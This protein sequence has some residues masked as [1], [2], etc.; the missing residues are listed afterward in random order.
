MRLMPDESL[1]IRDV[2]GSQV[3]Q[4]LERRFAAQR[5]A[6]FGETFD[7]SLTEFL[8]G[9]LFGTLFRFSTHREFLRAAHENEMPNFPEV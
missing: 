4:F 5:I 7:H 9:F 2:D 1:R 6:K 3:K 8:D